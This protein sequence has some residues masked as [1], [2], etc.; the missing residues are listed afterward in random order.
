MDGPAFVPPFSKM[1]TLCDSETHLADDVASVTDAT[2]LLPLNHHYPAPIGRS[3]RGDRVAPAPSASSACAS[4]TAHAITEICTAACIAFKRAY[5]CQKA[6]GGGG[7]NSGMRNGSEKERRLDPHVVGVS[8]GMR[9]VADPK[10]QCF[11]CEPL[12]QHSGRLLLIIAACNLTPTH[13]SLSK[14][15]MSSSRG[16]RGDLQS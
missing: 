11:E 5:G 14:R 4:A 6:G 12:L 2:L 7:E 10:V 15:V 3:R 1:C 8:Y 16:A 13:A 9:C